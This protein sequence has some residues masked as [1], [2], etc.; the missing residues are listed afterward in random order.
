MQERDILN[1]LANVANAQVGDENKLDPYNKFSNYIGGFQPSIPTNAAYNP[2]KEKTATESK[3]EKTSSDDSK[4]DDTEKVDTAEIIIDDKEMPEQQL[5]P[6]KSAVS[7]S[8]DAV[9]T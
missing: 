2:N 5:S 8:S 9:R 3:K 4:K 7:A 6:A 1:K